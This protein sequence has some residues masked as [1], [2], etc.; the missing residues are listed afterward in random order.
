M[1]TE[2]KKVAKKDVRVDTSMFQFA[3]GKMPRG[4]GS[5]A[6]EFVGHGPNATNEMF[7]AA[8]NTSFA[9]AKKAAVAAAADKG[10]WDVRVGS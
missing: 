9:E 10:F 1:K 2:T 6:F 5:W 7:W 8:S 4:R 3:H